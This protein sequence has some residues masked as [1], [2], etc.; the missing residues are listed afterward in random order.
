[1]DWNLIYRSRHDMIDLTAEIPE[2]EI[3]DIRVWSE[4]AQNIIFLR[5]TRK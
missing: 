2:A 3:H 4:E 5:V 1:M